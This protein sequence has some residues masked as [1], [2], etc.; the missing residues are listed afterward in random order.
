MFGSNDDFKAILHI[1][2]TSLFITEESFIHLYCFQTCTVK[3]ELT[4]TSE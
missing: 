1:N 4:T 3:P 2:L